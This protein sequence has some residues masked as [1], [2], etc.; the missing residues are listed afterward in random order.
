MQF[1]PRIYIYIYIH[2]FIYLFIIS[3]I[4]RIKDIAS[5]LYLYA[6]DEKGFA[7][8]CAVNIQNVANMKLRIRIRPETV[9]KQVLR[10][11]VFCEKLTNS[12]FGI[13]MHLNVRDL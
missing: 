12:Y 5:L 1:S 3:V 4:V 11:Y 2:L 6:W 9:D 10:T 7:I 8:K 13:F